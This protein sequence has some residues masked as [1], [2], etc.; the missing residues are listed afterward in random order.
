VASKSYL[1]KALSKSTK[2]AWREIGRESLAFGLFGEN[3]TINHGTEKEV[4]IGDVFSIGDVRMQVSQPR[5]PCWKLGRYARHSELP[6]KVVRTGF[7][8][9]YLRVLQT[10]IIESGMPFELAERPQP[11]WSVRRAHRTMY[12]KK[13]DPLF[14]DKSAL[15]DLPE[16]SDAWKHELA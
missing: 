4:C 13:D 14:T 5:Q 11:E 1:F 7:C 16:L 15:K 3:L 8:G 12:A 2:R 9:W 6:K 10:G